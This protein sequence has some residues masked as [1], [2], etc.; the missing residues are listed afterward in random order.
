MLISAVITDLKGDFYQ[1]HPK[2]NDDPMSV[3]YGSGGV[4][5]VVSQSILLPDQLPSCIVMYLVLSHV[6]SHQRIPLTQQVGRIEHL[7]TFLYWAC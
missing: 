3:Y 5:G 7:S 6:T 4:T 1:R 2:H